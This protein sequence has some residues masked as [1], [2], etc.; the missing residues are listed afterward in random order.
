MF[1][2]VWRQLCD[3][4]ADPLLS[5]FGIQTAGHRRWWITCLWFIQADEICKLLLLPE[6]STLAATGR[7]LRCSCAGCCSS[8]C[9]SSSCCWV[10]KAEAVTA[11][12]GRLL[13][14]LL[15]QLMYYVLQARK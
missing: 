9:G 7:L 4:L 3:G 12:R 8:R 5:R 6:N 15:L 1:A 13:L 11:G 2:S 10:P 14:G